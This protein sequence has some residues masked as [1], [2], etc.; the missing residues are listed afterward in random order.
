MSFFNKIYDITHTDMF[1]Y[2]FHRKNDKIFDAK[3][4]RS[5]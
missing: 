5:S 4:Q 1:K 2:I 3:S